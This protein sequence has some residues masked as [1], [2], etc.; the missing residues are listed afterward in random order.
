MYG[1]KNAYVHS[2]C[3]AL[4]P[5]IVQTSVGK[6]AVDK[7]VGQPHQQQLC[8]TVRH[9]TSNTISGSKWLF[10][11]SCYSNAQHRVGLANRL[12]CEHYS[13]AQSTL[14]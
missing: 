14:A 8:P 5:K 10:L 4:C 13:V 1:K 6:G 2:E 11:S 3:T 7:P 9:S 12:Q